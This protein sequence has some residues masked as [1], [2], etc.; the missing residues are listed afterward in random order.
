MVSVHASDTVVSYPLPDFATKSTDFH[1]TANDTT[2]P[3]EH[4]RDRHVA[5]VFAGGEVAIKIKINA[6]ITS[7]SI[8]PSSFGLK[9]TVEGDTLRVSLN[10]TQFNPRP[11]YLIF[12]INDLENLVVLVDPPDENA[13]SRHDPSVQ[14]VSAPPYRADPSGKHLA[15]TAIQSAIDKVSRTGGGIV[16]VPLGLYRVQCLML[17]SGVTLY[18][19][20]GAVIQG[21]DRLADY[22]GDA[23]YQTSTSKKGLPPVVIAKD[24]KTVAIRGRGWIDAAEGTIYTTD[25]RP[26][27]IEPRGSYHRVAIQVSNGT[28]FTLDGITARDGAGWSLLLNRVENIRITR[29]KVLGPMWRGNDGIDICGCNA[30]VDRCFVYTG[31]D[32][33]CTK[34][35]HPNYPVHD[36]HFRNSI[37]FARSAG[38]KV[39]MQTLSPQSEIYFENMDIIHAG[40]GLVVEHRGEI[41]KNDQ[42]DNPIRNIFFTDVRVEQVTGT[43]GESRNPIEIISKLPGRISNIFFNRVSVGNFGPQSSRISGYDAK[44]PVTKVVFE[45]LT[46]GGKPI[47]SVSAGDFKTKNASDIKFLLASPQPVT[48]NSR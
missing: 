6:P 16:Y 20:G 32:N 45:N 30:V 22:V 1:V 2:V 24:F 3:V 36:I 41:S 9:G 28:G 8:H 44:H 11:A 10:P 14:D 35:L 46:I 4:Y 19:A 27:E 15:T 29:F 7:Y 18:L 26:Q 39:G 21:S 42:G 48:T 40:R 12:R 38:V 34:A 23:T 31:D 37:G 17:K 33:F 25:G 47:D 13:P 5:N 43:G